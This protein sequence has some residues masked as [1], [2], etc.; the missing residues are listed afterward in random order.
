MLSNEIDLRKSRL[1][2]VG[3]SSF[4]SYKEAGYRDLPQIV[5]VIDNLTA[6]KELY[7]QDNDMLLPVCRDGNSVGISFL[8]AN[9]QTA[10]VGYR[11]LNNFEGRIALFCNESSEYTMLFEGNRTKLPNVPGRALVQ[12]DKATYECQMYLAF[13]GD[14]EYERVQNIQKYVTSCNER[15]VGMNARVIPEIPKCLDIGY[16]EKHYAQANTNDE[17]MIGLDYETIEPL[18]MNLNENDMIVLSGKKDVS[19]KAFAKYII[20]VFADKK[21]GKTELYVLDTLAG[22]WGELEILPQTAYYTTDADS[23]ISIVTEIG[24]IVEQRYQ[25]YINRRS[26]LQDESWIVVIVDNNDAILALSSNKNAMA[27]LKDIWGKYSGMKVIFVF[28]DINN[29]S[30]PFN[31]PEIMK[32]I[33]ERKKYIIFDEIS[34]I[35]TTDIPLSLT[36]K[37][38]KPLE[39]GDAYL[40]ED[41]DVKKIR[42]IN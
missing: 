32:I 33:K 1:A 16:V 13:D 5:V 15:Y 37:Y 42:T 7:L 11:Y 26:N 4:A 39:T 20:S 22:K 28:T 35:K 19:R 3:V 30:I 34:N 25:N 41:G 36:R 31:A 8:V 23:S 24:Q 27:T 40:V 2:E 17:L 12:I 29:A 18:S 6:L 9:G 14:K 38:S 10:G 21:F